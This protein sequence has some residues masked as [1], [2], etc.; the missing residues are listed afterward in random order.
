MMDVLLVASIAVVQQAYS[1]I[2]L[3][4]LSYPRGLLEYQT[5]DRK[6]RIQPNELEIPQ[7]SERQEG[8]SC[9]C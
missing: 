1:T 7:V 3:T 9:L 2:Q 5:S 4:V 8:P 6:E